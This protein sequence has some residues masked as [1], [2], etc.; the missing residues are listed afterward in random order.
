MQ[1]MLD[2]G[3]RKPPSER[4]AV[5]TCFGNFSESPPKDFSAELLLD[6]DTSIPMSR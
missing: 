2:Y 6:D 5:L 1:N 3:E 4:D